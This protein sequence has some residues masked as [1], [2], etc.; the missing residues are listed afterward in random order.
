[1][2]LRPGGL[3]MSVLTALCLYLL[4]GFELR[5]TGEV[6]PVSTSSQRLIC[7]L[8]LNDRLL[9][10]T[11]VAGTLWSEV[12]TA[13]ANANLRAALWRL[14]ATGRLLIDQ[15]PQHL[16]LASNVTVDFRNATALAHR[17]LDHSKH[18]TEHDLAEASR[19]ELSAD[20]LPTWYEDDWIV[21]QRERFRQLRLHALE[22][23]CERLI[24]A[25]RYGEA[26][27]AG[28]AAV[29]AEPLRESAHR[30]LIMAHLA[31]GNR[32]EAQRQYQ[33]CRHL[34][35]DEL[36]VEP[37][38]TLRELVCKDRRRLVGATTSS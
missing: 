19:R 3:P 24:T 12:P 8:A 32:G 9:P 17:L 11:Y 6:V 28:L 10:R 1:V 23:L 20:L 4:G 21:V 15:S 31:E 25:R 30:R 5:L 7:F 16:G 14:P 13:R 33:L 29:A 18:C 22:A 37:S 34:L 2:L 36:G 35:R 38:N 27:D 26:I